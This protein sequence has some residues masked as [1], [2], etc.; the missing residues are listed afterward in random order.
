MLHTKGGGR[1]E[2]VVEQGEEIADQYIAPLIGAE[3]DAGI[4]ID[5]PL[6][7]DWLSQCALNWLGDQGELISFNY[8]NRKAAYLGE[9]LTVGGTVLSVDKQTRVVNV[10]LHVKNE[11]DDVITPGGAELKVFD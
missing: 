11:D 9:T 4:V 1:L 10:Q 8:S 6:Q 3:K 5:G 2:L 7:G